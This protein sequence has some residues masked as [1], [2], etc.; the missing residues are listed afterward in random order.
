MRKRLFKS[1]HPNI[2]NSLN[3]LAGLYSSQRK[4]IQAESLYVDAFQ[5]CQRIWGKNH[6]TTL[7]FKKNLTTLQS[8]LVLSKV[9]ESWLN[10]LVK[11][12]LFPFQFLWLLVKPIFTFLKTTKANS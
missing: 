7:I 12:L 5:M 6:P 2:A 1:D 8:Q 3:N 10:N 9:S 11:I 4:Y